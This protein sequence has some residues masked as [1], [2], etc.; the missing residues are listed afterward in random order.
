MIGGLLIT[1]RLDEMD[2]KYKGEMEAVIL[3]TGMCVKTCRK[4]KSNRGSPLFPQSSLIHSVVRSPWH[5]AD[6]LTDT[7]PV[8]ANAYSVFV[9]LL[10]LVLCVSLIPLNGIFTHWFLER[11]AVLQFAGLTTSVSPAKNEHLM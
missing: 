6:T 8:K 10:Y 7:V 4:R 3:W 5:F 9:L 1:A 2:P 11:Q